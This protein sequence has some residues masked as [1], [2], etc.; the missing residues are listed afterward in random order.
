MS[1]VVGNLISSFVLGTGEKPDPASVNMLMTIYIVIASVGCIAFI[2]LRNEK[3][4][5][6]VRRYLFWITKLGGKG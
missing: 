4:S 2:L 5:H 6:D 3:P 1:Q